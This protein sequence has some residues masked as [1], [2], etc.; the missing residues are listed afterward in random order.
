[1]TATGR[2]L[3]SVFTTTGFV[4]LALTGRVVLAG[5]EPMIERNIQEL[6]Q[7]NRQ[8]VGGIEGL[9]KN[10]T[11]E[12]KANVKMDGDKAVVEIV[13]K[14]IEPG[15]EADVRSRGEEPREVSAPV[16]EGKIDY[17]TGN[18]LLPEGEK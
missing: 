7:I 11:V 8:A 13:E 9:P 12:L 3:F 5:N 2:I 10:G 15:P 6:D 16:R 4:I 17:G 14:K 18:T 1:V